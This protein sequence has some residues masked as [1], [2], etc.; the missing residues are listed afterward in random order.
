MNSRNACLYSPLLALIFIGCVAGEHRTVHIART[1]DASSIKRIQLREVNGEIHIAAAA[2][3]TIGLDATVHTWTQHPDP[4]KENEGFFET[5]VA[6][7]TLIIGRREHVH[8]SWF[9]RNNL[10][11]DYDLKVPPELALDVHTVNGP[12]VTRGVDGETVVSTVNGSID[13][14]TPG[15][16]ELTAHTVNGRIETKF[17]KLFNGAS[18]KTVNGRVTAVLP[19][20][21]SFVGDFSQVNGDFEASFPLNIHSN[22]GRRR[23]TGEVNGGQHELK[24]TTVNGDIKLDN[25]TPPA[26][27]APLATPIP[28]APPAAPAAP[29][30]T[31]T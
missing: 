6:G 29:A 20:S 23:V 3:G 31:N 13:I 26:P 25:G 19:A 14:E 15:S 16:N 27:P 8:F 11:I 28:P 18:L 17:A 30:L 7:D 12:V 5:R 4:K 2:P 21:A 9:G 10:A 22:P 1:F 24:I